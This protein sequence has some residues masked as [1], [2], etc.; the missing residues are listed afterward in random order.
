LGLGLGFWLRRRLR[1]RRRHRTSTSG[2]DGA[3]EAAL[4]LRKR[5]GDAGGVVLRE[6]ERDVRRTGE[7]DALRM[8]RI[9]G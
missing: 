9:L 6:R 8:E 5:S 2:S 4:S 1:R 7:S 3:R